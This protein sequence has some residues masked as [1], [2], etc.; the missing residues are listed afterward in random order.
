MDERGLEEALRKMRE[1]DLPA[2]A[3]ASFERAWHQAVSGDA[4]LIPEATIEPAEGIP[5]MDQVAAAAA[6]LALFDKLCV[7]NGMHADTGIHAQ[8][9]LQL[10]TGERLR[11]RPSLG[12]WISYG[13][14]SENDNLPGFL[15]IQ[16][17]MGNG[18][19]RNFSNAFLPALYQ[20]TAVGRVGQKTKDAKIL[21]LTNKLLS[22]SDPNDFIEGKRKSLLSAQASIQLEAFSIVVLIN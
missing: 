9:F 19:P 22:T 21:N 11:K 20:G 2:A 15:T 5:A 12:S 10:H 4:G 3:C 17:S 18:G 16:P 1:A 6:D 8:S 7:I 14:G 13:L